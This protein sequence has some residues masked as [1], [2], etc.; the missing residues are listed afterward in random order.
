MEKYKNDAISKENQAQKFEKENYN[1]EREYQ[2]LKNNT[3]EDIERLRREAELQKKKTEDNERQQ[4]MKVSELEKMLKDTQ[5]EALKYRTEYERI[6][7][8][9]QG[10]LNKVI[11]QTLIDHGRSPNLL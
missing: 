3:V 7:G 6:C 9:L 1:W 5:Y 10:N 11:N 8:I 4:G 2:K